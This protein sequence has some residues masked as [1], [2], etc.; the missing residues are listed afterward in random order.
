MSSNLQAILLSLSAFAI[1][2]VHDVVIKV[3]GG[4]YAAFQIVFFSVLMGFPLVTV[5]LLRDATVDSL[6][7]KHPWWTL[8]RTTAA[9]IS[10]SCVFYAFSALP[11]AEVYAILFAMPLLITILAIP[12]LG[13][14]VGFRRAI[15]VMVGLGG[16][17]IVLQPG[18][19][20]LTLGHLAALG[21]A[22]FSSL[23]SIIVRKIGRD[24]RSVV[25]ILYPMVA[26][27]ILMAALMPIYYQPMPFQ[28]LALTLLISALA[29][30]AMLCM[31]SAYRKGEAAI[32]APMQ[33]SQILWATLFGWLFFAEHPKAT[34]ALG[35]AVIIASGL[36]IVLRENTSGASNTTP[37]LRTRTRM[38]TG[39]S[40]R[41]GLMIKAQ[42]GTAGPSAPA[43]KKTPPPETKPHM[44]GLPGRGSHR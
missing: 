36:Y 9:V 11:L 29:L 7:P 31:I 14:K 21:A 5:M 17:L 33:Y 19:T 34:T 1:F 22:V 28:D 20:E 26:N 39:T 44:R 12:V 25:L 10:G 13:E 35:A 37:V 15:A 38:A 4:S 43:E 24:E 2:A 23:A 18:A 32:V 3:L 8:A 16:V 30:L 27:F 41:V 40:P 6:R 42:D